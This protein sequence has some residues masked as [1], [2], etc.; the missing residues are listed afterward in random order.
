MALGDS[1]IFKSPCDF[2]AQ[3]H[4]GTAGLSQERVPTWV[5]DGSLCLVFAATAA[6]KSTFSRTYLLVKR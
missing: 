4:L 2:T 3:R 5:P 6:L 1:R